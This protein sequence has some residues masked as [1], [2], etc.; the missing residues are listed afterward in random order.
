MK[1]YL[2]NTGNATSSLLNT[3]S[4]SIE[5]IFHLDTDIQQWVNLENYLNGSEHNS[6]GPHN[7][8][9]WVKD[10]EEEPTVESVQ[11]WRSRLENMVSVQNETI[12]TLCSSILLIAQNGIKLTLGSPASWRIH[13]NQLLSS[14]NE[15]L[16]QA[17]W[18]G[19]NLAAH[20]EGLKPNHPSA[21]YF[22]EIETRLNIDLTSQV[23][24]YPSKV[25]LTDLLGWIDLHK[26]KIKDTTH[27]DNWASPYTQDMVRIGALA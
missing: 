26:L 8:E 22:R 14:Q 16:L 9:E 12:N 3:I 15:C 10:M 11:Y 1:D 5:R 7:F 4:N 25:I 23:S 6:W 2:E 27:A 21:Q 20:V 24:L 19:R 17:I 18:H 13:N